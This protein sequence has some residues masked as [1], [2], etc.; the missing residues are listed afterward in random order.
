M[1]EVL[2]AYEDAEAIAVDMP[3]GLNQ[4]PR[5]CDVEARKLLRWKHP[6]VFPAPDPR[7]IHAATYEEAS[8]LSR[9]LTDQG[10]SVQTFAVFPKIVEVNEAMTPA[11]QSR[12]IEVHPEV[13]FCAMAG[14]PMRHPKRK[15]E[16]IE[17]RRKQLKKALGIEIWTRTE[18]A[19]LVKPA[20]ADDV[21]DAIAAAWTAQRLVEGEAVRLPDEP[22]VDERGLRMEIV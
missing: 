19:H 2:A 15:A 17:E 12:I 22:E 3:I 1:R 20:K 5:Q 18:A 21:L 8:G 9:E 4:G 14:E 10:L 6:A 16:G 7:L 13:S 11:M